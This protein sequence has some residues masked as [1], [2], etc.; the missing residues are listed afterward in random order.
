MVT[1]PSQNRRK[2]RHSVSSTMIHYVIN[3]NTII[4]LLKYCCISSF[5]KKKKT[6][7]FDFFLLSDVTWVL[8]I[9][10]LSS[11]PTPTLTKSLPDLPLGLQSCNYPC[12]V[13]GSILLPD[14][15]SAPLY[16]EIKTIGQIYRDQLKV[17]ISCTNKSSFFTPKPLH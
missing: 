10:E 11:N 4:L 1:P 8:G 7:A 16:Y 3:H 15:P 2:S 14:G 13:V 17:F 5:F 6:R 12:V 9:F